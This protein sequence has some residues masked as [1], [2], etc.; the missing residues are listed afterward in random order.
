MPPDLHALLAAQPDAAHARLACLT[1]PQLGLNPEHA[2]AAGLL[3][4]LGTSPCPSRGT[5]CGA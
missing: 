4:D 2:H 1:A 5:T 3:H